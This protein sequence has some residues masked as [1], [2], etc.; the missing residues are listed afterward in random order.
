MRRVP[1]PSRSS[2]GALSHSLI[3]RSTSDPA[4]AANNLAE[5]YRATGR[6][7]QAEPLFQ[8]ALG[9][10]R[11]ATPTPSIPNL[12]RVAQQPSPA[13]TPRPLRAGRAALPARS[14]D[15]REDAFPRA[16][17]L[18]SSSSTTWPGLTRTP[19]ATRRPS[20]STSALLRSAK[21]T[22]GP[23]HP[24]VAQSLNNLAGLYQA[25]GRY[26]QAEPLFQRA[27]SPS[28]KRR[29]APSTPLSRHPAQ[30]P[31]RALPGHRPLTRRPSRS[32]S[33]PSR[34]W[35]ARACRQIIHTCSRSR[36]LCRCSRP[37]RPQRG[38]L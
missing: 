35:M 2:T 34:S 25:T 33:A 38:G 13:V 28:A 6:Y 29:S 27:S 14:C 30:Q 3:S 26:A 5:L 22:L 11:Q 10:S 23:E 31:G 17:P 1:S 15:R 24:N 16:P 32:T 19:A 7:A 4:G 18:S 20:R 37:S 9:D 8:R 21:Q 36:E 12:S